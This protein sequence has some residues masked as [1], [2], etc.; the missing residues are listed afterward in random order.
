MSLD[1]KILEELKAKNPRAVV[2]TGTAT[3]LIVG[4]KALSAD[5]D[6]VVVAPPSRAQWRRFKSMA[7]DDRKRPDALEMILRDCLMHPAAPAFESML[8]MRPA[9][10]EV[11]G[12]Q[13]LELA[14]AGLEVEKNG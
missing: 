11:F 10:I 4:E 3:A 1:P 9:L 8:D 13:V 2:L 7:S 6:T 5:G 12:E 14:G